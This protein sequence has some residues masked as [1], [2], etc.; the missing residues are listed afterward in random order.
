MS[1][2]YSSMLDKIGFNQWTPLASWIHW[3]S[4]R[5]WEGLHIPCRALGF[6]TCLR[7]SDW[8]IPKKKE[9]LEAEDC[10]WKWKLCPPHTIFELGG[11]PLFL[12]LPP[13]SISYQVCLCSLPRYSNCVTNNNCTSSC[14]NGSSAMPRNGIYD[15]LNFPTNLWE[16]Y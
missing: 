10:I 6:E 15:D 16:V 4:G 13:V 8:Q 11:L 2:L 7:S 12:P 9:R 5:H 1:E 3:T 14:I